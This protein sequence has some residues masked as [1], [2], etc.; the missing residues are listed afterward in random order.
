MPEELM[1]A[2]K[3]EPQPKT[4]PNCGKV[5]GNCAELEAQCKELEGS[6]KKL[7]KKKAE[8]ITEAKNI[9]MQML[10]NRE[11]TRKLRMKVLER[12]RDFLKSQIAEQRALKNSPAGDDSD[13]DEDSP[14]KTAEEKKLMAELRRNS[15]QRKRIWNQLKSARSGG[16]TKVV[17][18]SAKPKKRSRKDKKYRKRD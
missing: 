10:K 15:L 14:R 17:K 11:D 2:E 5:G 7:N 3:Q 4:C 1:P 12:R 16:K 18:M 9:N 13:E 6:D 8:H